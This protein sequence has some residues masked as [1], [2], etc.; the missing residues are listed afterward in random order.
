MGDMD[1]ALRERAVR[2]PASGGGKLAA[3]LALPQ[4]VV[5]A[6]AECDFATLQ[7][8][9]LTV[10]ESAR[11]EQSGEYRYD[12]GL[13]HGA[14]STRST[15]RRAR[16]N[17]PRR[18]S[19]STAARA[20]SSRSCPARRTPR[21]AAPLTKW[22]GSPPPGASAISGAWPE[23]ITSRRIDASSPRSDLQ[24]RRAHP[25]G[26][27]LRRRAARPSGKILARHHALPRDTRARAGLA[28]PR[29]PPQPP[30]G[31]APAAAA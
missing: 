30:G 17:L 12:I 10:E 28:P 23:S 5:A 29:Q 3:D 19:R 9:L 13:S 2:I 16:R 18:R 25:M 20:P 31:S 24:G 8:D 27:G 22:R 6:L 15:G 26:R 4:P 21:T 11:D 14:W 1:T 7:L